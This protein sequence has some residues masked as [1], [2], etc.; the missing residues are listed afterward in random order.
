M[1]NH[2]WRALGLEGWAAQVDH[3]D[4]DERDNRWTNLREASP[5][6]YS[7]NRHRVNL[8]TRRQTFGSLKT[9]EKAQTAR[10]KARTKRLKLSPSCPQESPR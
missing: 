9:L 6:A 3:I 10:Q 2:G 1:R 8:D 5:T 4:A 7:L